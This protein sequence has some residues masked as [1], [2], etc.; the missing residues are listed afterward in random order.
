MIAAAANIHNLCTLVNG[1][2]LRQIYTL[3]VEVGCTTKEHLNRIGF[4][5]RYIVFPFNAKSNQKRTMRF[6]MRMPRRLKVRRYSA[7]MIDH[8]GYLD[9]FPGAKASDKI[10]EMELN[11]ILLNII[12][13]SCSSQAYV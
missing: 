8:N 5:F 1:K 2:S 11:E 9:T 12:P 7:C 13:N 6:G 10:C 3:S 4:G